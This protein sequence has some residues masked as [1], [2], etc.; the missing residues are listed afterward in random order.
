MTA[1]V[2]L[3]GISLGMPLRRMLFFSLAM[4]MM[5]YGLTALSLSLGALLPNFREA[6]P[7]RIVSGF[8]GTVCLISS[9]IYILTGMM[10]VL[11]PSWSSLKPQITT[12]PPVDWRLDVSSLG[13]LLVL[14]ALVGGAPYF[15]AK[16]RTK[17]LDYL[18]DS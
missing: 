6:N 8:G 14:T 3:S 5:S 7:A 4:M 17:S 18:R 16:K 11:I 15:F 2:C 10:V 1:L 13:I 9:F 12:T